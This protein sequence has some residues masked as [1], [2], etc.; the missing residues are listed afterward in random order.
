MKDEPEVI[1]RRPAAVGYAYRFDERRAVA[2][3]DLIL[4]ALSHWWGCGCLADRGCR[5]SQQTANQCGAAFQEFSSTRS[6]RT[7]ESLLQMSF[8]GNRVAQ[9]YARLARIVKTIGMIGMG[10]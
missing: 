10:Q 2:V 4:V 1:G 7:H 8:A 6:F 3:G 5:C 9:A